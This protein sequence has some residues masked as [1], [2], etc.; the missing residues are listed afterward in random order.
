MRWLNIETNTI[1]RPEY[2]GSDPTTRATW[3][4]VCI[5]SAEQ[6]NDGRVHDCRHWNDRRWM[7]TC[8]VLAS[9]I[10][11][12]SPLL[13]FRGNDL[14]VWGYP[15]DHEALMRRK[16]DIARKNGQKGGRKPH[17]RPTE[18]TQKPTSI[19]TSDATL[20]TDTQPTQETDT[21]P[22]LPPTSASV[23]KGNVKKGKVRERNR[24]ENIPPESPKGDTTPPPTPLTTNQDDATTLPDG[25]KPAS[26]SDVLTYFATHNA[27]E[28]DALDFFD[29]YEANGWKQG[30]NRPLASWQA[31]SRK[32]I[33]RAQGLVGI[34]QKN[35]FAGGA[36]AA[37]A[38]GRALPFDPS[39]PD[40]HTGG[41]PVFSKPPP[42][43]P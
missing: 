17:T 20:P 14:I 6:E 5:W 22:T 1:R 12:A 41:L 38:S 32:W 13:T 27:S 34:V 31:A 42:S 15:H 25:R 16:A 18:P 30:G 28:T 3:L 4:N 8:G 24:K 33:R 29:H 21:K 36:P 26:Q 9:E 37:A 39:Q 35:S 43:Q 10:Q 40:A 7:Q 19:P 2:V 11:T 23:K